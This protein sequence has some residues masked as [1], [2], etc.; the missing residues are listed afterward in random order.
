MSGRGKGNWHPFQIAFIVL[1]IK[2]FTEP[3][4]K[5]REIM[6]LIWFPTGGGKTEAYLGLTAFTIFL[7]KSIQMMSS[8]HLLNMNWKVYLILKVLLTPLI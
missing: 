1:N 7:R 8:Y 5:D 3:H 2:S 4:S 6:D